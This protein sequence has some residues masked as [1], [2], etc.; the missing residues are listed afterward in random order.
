MAHY[1]MYLE[2][3]C[4]NKLIF[5]FAIGDR[6]ITGPGQLLEM[7]ELLLNGQK[8]RTFKNVRPPDP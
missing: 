2:F 3:R 5:P 8:I 1:P 7:E 4:V 6:I